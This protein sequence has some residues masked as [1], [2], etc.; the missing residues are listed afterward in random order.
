M[1][2]ISNK[3]PKYIPVPKHCRLIPICWKVVPLGKEKWRH[4]I[5]CCMGIHFWGNYLPDDVIL[6]EADI[7]V[8]MIKQCVYCGKSKI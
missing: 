6:R 3:V 2:M 5:L 7:R 4:Q 1:N 8:P